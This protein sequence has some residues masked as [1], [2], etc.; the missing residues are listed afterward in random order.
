M[1][2]NSMFQHSAFTMSQNRRDTAQ[3]CSIQRIYLNMHTGILPI[4][5]SEEI[6]IGRFSGVKIGRNQ[7]DLSTFGARDYGISRKHIKVIKASDGQVYIVDL[8]STN[9]TF[10]N[11]E[12]LEPYVMYPTDHGDILRLGKLVIHMLFSWYRK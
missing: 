12:R 2:A 5:V 4:E 8:S 1:V 3:L 7:V 9:G 10:L 11:G 6:V